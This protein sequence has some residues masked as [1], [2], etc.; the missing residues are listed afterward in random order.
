MT[1]RARGFLLIAYR[2]RLVL[3]LSPDWNRCL[4]CYTRTD[5]CRLR[6]LGSRTCGGSVPP[7]DRQLHP[8]SRALARQLLP[9]SRS[10][11]PRTSHSGDGTQYLLLPRTLYLA[12]LDGPHL[13]VSISQQ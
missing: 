12:V 11:L 5:D 10:K 8:R 6:E 1:P 3:G 13:A 2:L 7:P 4:G 9:A